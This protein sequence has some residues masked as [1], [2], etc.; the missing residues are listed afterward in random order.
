MSSDDPL[1]SPA[2]PPRSARGASGSGI[3][4]P[5]RPELPRTPLQAHRF[6][7]IDS[8]QQALRHSQFEV[9]Q[10]QP[11]RFETR[12]FRAAPRPGLAATLGSNAVGVRSRGLLASDSADVVVVVEV[13]GG[14][15]FNGIPLRMGTVLVFPP[16]IEFEGHDTAGFAWANLHIG[17]EDLLRATRALAGRGFDLPTREILV[18]PTLPADAAR[19]RALHG[20][21]CLPPGESSDP[22]TGPT[23]ESV[24]ETWLGI[25]ARALAGAGHDDF[26]GARRVGERH[27]VFL[28][29]EAYLRARVTDPVY[30]AELCAATGVSERTL[31]Y[32]FRERLGV[33]PIAY[34]ASL[35][36]NLT[37]LAL[38]GSAAAPE[39]SVAE[40][41]RRFGFLHLG[42]FAARYRTQFG[43]PPS[44]TLR[45]GAA[46]ASGRADRAVSA[47]S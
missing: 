46:E 36:L 23:A 1:P 5:H 47:P 41:A 40:V 32:V 28:A 21:G 27:R 8:L 37:R 35:R 3:P 26:A 6:S 16:G 14:A 44:V 20:A 43:E 39:A 34:L 10:V 4:A 18:R 2:P 25:A 22:T 11:G 29:A 12:L 15:Y 7:S 17:S 19:L 42:R 31:E 9:A 45:R 38:V 33:T 24:V 13:G 30:M